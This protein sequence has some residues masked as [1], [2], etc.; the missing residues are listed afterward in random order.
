MQKK[1]WI[2]SCVLCPVRE[3]LVR[4]PLVRV[5]RAILF[6]DKIATVQRGLESFLLASCEN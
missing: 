6:P 2:V 3:C 1:R 5:P 4:E